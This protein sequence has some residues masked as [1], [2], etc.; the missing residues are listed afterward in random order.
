MKKLFKLLGIIGILIVAGSGGAESFERILF[1]KGGLRVNASAAGDVNG[2]GYGDLVTNIP[3][4]TG[5]GLGGPPSIYLGPAPDSIADVILSWGDTD[6]SAG[7]VN[8]DG[9]SDIISE[10]EYGG[11]AHIYFGGSPM[12]TLPDI[13]FNDDAIEPYP[14]GMGDFN[15]D[16]YDDVVI[17]FVE[18]NQWFT[19]VYFGGTSMDTTRDVILRGNLSM[20]CWAPGGELGGDINGDGYFDIVTVRQDSVNHRDTLLIYYGDS[21]PDNIVD[22]S[23]VM[24]SISDFSIRGNVNGDEY[25]DIV[26]CSSIETPH[27]FLGGTTFDPVADIILSQHFRYCGCAGDVNGDGFDDLLFSTGGTKICLFYGGNPMDDISDWEITGKDHIVIGTAG[28]LNNDG[29]DEF[30]TGKIGR[31]GDFEPPYIEVWRCNVG[32][33]EGKKGAGPGYRFSVSPNPFVQST[34]LEYSLTHPSSVS[35]RIY[36]RKG[37]LAKTLINNAKMPSGAHQITWGGDGDN[38]IVLPSGIYFCELKTD[39]STYK[40]KV[41]KIVSMRK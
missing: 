41:K 10:D 36:D 12:D 25:S 20:Y 16:G 14:Y 38:G 3:D 21:I 30:F 8:G 23:I 27:I 40:A 34:T 26:I 2:D 18:S 15:G 11:V 37:S 32:K 35:L 24:D 39:V 31:T 28:D 1:L 13:T 5:Y 33:E 4:G 17:P 19:G 6:V 29:Q 9:Y 7:D 22:I